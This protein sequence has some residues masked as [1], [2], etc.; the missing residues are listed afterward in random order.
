MASGKSTWAKQ[1]CIDNPEFVRINK[2]DIR[3][4]LGSPKFSRK[5]EKAVL[6]IEHKMGVAILESGNSLIVDSTN[7]AKIHQDYWGQVAKQMQ[8]DMTLRCFATPVEECIERDSKREKS[9]GKAVIL[10]MYEKYIKDKN[11]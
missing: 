8:L 5:F 9:V 7:F 11:F 2:D 6:D 4:L 10:Q 3:I 1:Y